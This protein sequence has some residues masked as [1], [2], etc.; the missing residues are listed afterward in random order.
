MGRLPVKLRFG[1][2]GSTSHFPL[3]SDVVMRIFL[4]RLA[5]I[6]RTSAAAAGR[7]MQSKLSPLVRR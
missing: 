5:L 6:S 4:A 7:W 3:A 1:L 2:P